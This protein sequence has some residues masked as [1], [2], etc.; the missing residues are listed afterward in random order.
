MRR[1]TLFTFYAAVLAAVFGFLTTASFLRGDGKIAPDRFNGGEDGALPYA[2]LIS[3]EAGNLYGTTTSGGAYGW[4]TV[5][6]L[7]PKNDTWT[8]NIL[9]S[10]CRTNGCPDGTG[11]LSAL[12]FDRDGNLYGTCSISGPHNAGAV[13]RLAPKNGTWTETVLY[14]FDRKDGAA[15]F[16]SVIFDAAGNL[17]GTTEQGGASGKQCGGAGCGT[18]FKLTLGANGTWTETVL[19]SFND[20]GRDGYWPQG[21]LVFDASG[22]LYGTTYLGGTGSCKDEL[23]TGCGVVFELTPG[24]SGAWTETILHSFNRKDGYNPTSSLVFDSVGNLYGVTRIGGALGKGTVFQLSRRAGVTWTETLLHSFQN[25]GKDGFYPYG[26]LIF[27]MNGNLYGTTSEGSPNGDTC[28]GLPGCGTVFQLV[29]STDGKWKEKVLH[30]YNGPDGL[31]PVAGPIFGADGVLYGTTAYGGN[32]KQ[33]AGDGC[34]TVFRLA[35]G[36]NGSWVETVLHKFNFGSL[37][38]TEKSYGSSANALK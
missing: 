26:T 21:G 16:A 19:H 14:G 10:F 6:Q 18:V 24:A 4:G 1:K 28:G 12:I 20:N 2:G 36:T 23:G 35:P 15:P 5:F 27:D 32:V 30:G 33:C 34:G 31:Y 38:Q 9:Y 37:T 17:Y 7:V 11:G 22:N 3:D 13:F 25:D 29:H 8:E